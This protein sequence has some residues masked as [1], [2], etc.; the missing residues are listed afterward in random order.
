MPDGSADS[1]EFGKYLAFAQV[2]F[3]MVVPVVLGLVA[4]NYLGSRPWGVTAGTVLGLVGGLWHL[5]ILARRFEEAEAA[6]R[7]R[8]EQ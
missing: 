4:D 5:V 2:G 3:E 8:N 1:K 7:R 6:R